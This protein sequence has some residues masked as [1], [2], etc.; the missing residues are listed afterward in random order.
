M[1][2]APQIP[3]VPPGWVLGTAI[4]LELQSVRTFGMKAL[5]VLISLLPS[6]RR[7]VPRAA[8]SKALQGGDAD[9]RAGD[10]KLE[11]PNPGELSSQSLPK[12][13]SP[14]TKPFLEGG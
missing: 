4:V 5:A 3:A 2:G 6:S 13:S 12:S 14:N 8:E 10:T 1:P 7:L 11:M 9:P